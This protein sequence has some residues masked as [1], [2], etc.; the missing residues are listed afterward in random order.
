[1]RTYARENN[2]VVQVDVR[3]FPA[4]VDFQVILD[5]VKV[6]PDEY[7]DPP[8]ETCDGLEHTRDNQ[9]DI[10]LPWDG[11][12]EEYYHSIGA[13]K[14]VAKQLTARSMADRRQYLMG[15]YANGYEV[16]VVSCDFQGF[17]DSVGGVDDYA[18]ASGEASRE[19]ALN[20]AAEMQAAGFEIKNLSDRCQLYKQNRRDLY[21]Q[22]VHLFDCN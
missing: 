5:A 22:R 21:S 13:A 6:S 14:Q 7:A 8:W 17:G 11:S 10:S 18:Y 4:V 3:T 12:L 9:G 1:M 19:V 20:V 16:W 2:I 15:V